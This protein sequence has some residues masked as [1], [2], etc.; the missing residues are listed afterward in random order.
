MI[1]TPTVEDMI[2]LRPDLSN[3]RMLQT[4]WDPGPT[5]RKRHLPDQGRRI[6]LLEGAQRASRS[7]D[8]RPK[9]DR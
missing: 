4:C 9:A 1:H 8:S 6:E 5:R 2:G 3:T 7:A